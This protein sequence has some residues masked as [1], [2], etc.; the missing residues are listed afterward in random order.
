M[1]FRLTDPSPERWKKYK[2]CTSTI[3]RICVEHDIIL[4]KRIVDN[5]NFELT[6]HFFVTDNVKFHDAVIEIAKLL[7]QHKLTNTVVYS[8]V[9]KEPRKFNSCVTW[10]L[11]DNYR[12]DS[13]W[14]HWKELQ[15][16]IS[17]YAGFYGVRQKLHHDKKT[18]ST[19]V[20][21][22]FTDISEWSNFSFYTGQIVA[23]NNLEIVPKDEQEI[24]E[25]IQDN[26]FEELSTVT[27][28]HKQLTLF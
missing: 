26:L 20:C 21:S 11:A 22:E 17:E 18:Y 28:T 27:K 24:S 2:D 14:Y 23:K 15:Q 16:T 9:V 12:S 1:T 3:D 19:E 4:E 10:T 25:V 7:A 5:E 6:E 8:S 13:N